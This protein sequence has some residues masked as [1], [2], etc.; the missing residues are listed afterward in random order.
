MRR[1][2]I[3]LR[4]QGRGRAMKVM[5]GRWQTTVPW[6]LLVVLAFAFPAGCNNSHSGKAASSTVTPRPTSTPPPTKTPTATPNV[7]DIAVCNPA[8]GPFS[9]TIDNPYFPLVVGQVSVFDGIEDGAQVHLEITVLDETEVVADV[10]TRVVEERQ[11][12]DGELVE[13]ARN[14][15]VQAPDGTVCYYGEDVDE[16]DNGRLIGHDSQWRAGVGGNLPGI[17]M[18]AHPTV[19]VEYNQEFAPGVALDH[20]KVIATGQPLTV[21]A[22]MFTDTII[23][24]ETTPLEPGVVE[25]KTYAPGVG[26]AVDNTLK[27]TSY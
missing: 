14:F 7:L 17:I 2:D 8:N 9:L 19:G 5:H 25:H 1:A 20:A 10:T 22:G 23:T 12:E 21:P 4:S 18:P 15:F 11:A 13:L 3:F 6:G 27:L 16:Y 24:E 26:T